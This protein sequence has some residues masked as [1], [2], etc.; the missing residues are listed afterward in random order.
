MY[1]F[2]LFPYKPPLSS[3]KQNQPKAATQ[4]AI[5]ALTS[6]HAAREAESHAKASSSQGSEED[7]GRNLSAVPLTKQQSCAIFKAR[8]PLCRRIPAWLII[9]YR[10]C[11]R[12]RKLS[13]TGSKVNL[14]QRL[15]RDI[16]EAAR[17]VW[18][19]G[20]GASEGAGEVENSVWCW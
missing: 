15:K 8:D 10:E 16:S 20:P 1:V 12:Y 7:V 17:L 19:N 18:V 9:A 14:I 6:L 2:E 4:L 13:T 3:R 11:L 5:S